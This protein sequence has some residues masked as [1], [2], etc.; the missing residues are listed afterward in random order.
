MDL[1][2]LK[3]K[4]HQASWKKSVYEV[5]KDASINLK[6][7]EKLKNVTNV[8][9]FFTSPYDLE[10]VDYVDKYVPAYKIGYG[11]ITYLEIVNKIASKKKPVIL[12][13]G[14]STLK[15]V[16]G[17]VKNILSKNETMFDAMA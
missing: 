4:S 14:A 2:N 13:T 6:W 12:A 10:L 1:K 7:T 15:D 5:Y 8:G 16:D 3:K 17:A 11:D 9:L